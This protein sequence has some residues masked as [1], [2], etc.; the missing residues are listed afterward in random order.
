MTTTAPAA[1]QGQTYTPATATIH[2]TMNGV[3]ITK[4]DVLVKNGLVDVIDTVLTPM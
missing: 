2:V 3:N 1:G 4:A